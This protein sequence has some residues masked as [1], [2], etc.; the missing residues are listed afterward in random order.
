MN[1][2]NMLLNNYF[3]KQKWVV[4]KIKK[5]LNIKNRSKQKYKKNK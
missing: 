1:I 4:N 5:K 3:I 2:I